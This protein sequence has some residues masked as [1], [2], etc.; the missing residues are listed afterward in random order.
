MAHLAP[1]VLGRGI[2]SA[3]AAIPNSVGVCTPLLIRPCASS[4]LVDHAFACI[5]ILPVDYFVKKHLVREASINIGKY[6]WGVGFTTRR[7]HTLRAAHC[8]RLTGCTVVL[9]SPAKGCGLV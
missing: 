2:D 3:P 8:L 1:A 9:R 6:I 4:D 7:R 5:L